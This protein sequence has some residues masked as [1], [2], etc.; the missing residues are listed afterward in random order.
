[1]VGMRLFALLIPVLIGCGAVDLETPDLPD[2][3]AGDNAFI[4]AAWEAWGMKGTA[5][6]DVKYLEGDALNCGDGSHVGKGFLMLH[7]PAGSF[8]V[9]PGTPGA[10]C[11]LGV[12]ILDS[13]VI[14]VAWHGALSGTTANA[15]VHELCHFA[16][17]DDWHLGP[18]MIGPGGK[19]EQITAELTR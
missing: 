5:R 10:R 15:I 6:P 17:T 1:M 9:Q 7:T 16:T 13:N 4:K 19:I 14:W 12:A 8:F 3:K 2:G 11:D 18:C